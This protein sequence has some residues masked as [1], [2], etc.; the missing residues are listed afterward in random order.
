M[1]G[2]FI[3]PTQGNFL[4]VQWGFCSYCLLKDLSLPGILPLS[5]F[6]SQLVLL[7]TVNM[8]ILPFLQTE[9]WPLFA[10]AHPL[11]FTTISLFLKKSLTHRFFIWSIPAL[12]PLVSSPAASHQFPEAVPATLS[13][14]IHTSKIK[15]I[16]SI[17]Q[18]T[19]FLLFKMLLN[20]EEMKIGI[21]GI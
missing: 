13:L 21:R 12:F 6:S 11:P 19:G 5:V 2:L 18:L 3:S 9:V 16:F 7:S 1:K 20:I 17:F 8:R 4:C 10:N 15:H 14:T